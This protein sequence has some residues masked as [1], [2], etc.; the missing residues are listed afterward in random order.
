M[1]DIAMYRATLILLAFGMLVGLAGCPTPNTNPVANAGSDQQVDVGTTVT[2]DGSSS[3]DADGDTLTYQW[4]FDERPDESQTSLSGAGMAGPSFVPDRPGT[5][6]LSL[7]VL[8]TLGS[9]TPDTVTITVAGSLVTVPELAG[10]TEAEAA[11]ALTDAGLI[12]GNTTTLSSPAVPAGQILSQDPIAGFEALPDSA[13]DVVVSSG[14]ASVTVPN[15]TGQPQSDAEAAILGAGLTLGTVTPTPSDTIPEGEVIS[16]SVAPDTVVDEGTA[17]DLVVSAGQPIDLRLANTFNLRGALNDPENENVL[18]PENVVVDAGSSQAYITARLTSHIAIHDL[19]DGMITGTLDSGFVLPGLKYPFLAPD[20]GALYVVD[21]TTSQ[22]ARIDIATNTVTATAP[23]GDGFLDGESDGSSIYI[24][25]SATPSLLVLN[26]DTLAETSS[27]NV[28]D[29]MVGDM[30]MDSANGLLYILDI[31]GVGDDGTLSV[32]DTN[33]SSH[34]DTISFTMP[35]AGASMALRLDLDTVGQRFFILG[36]NGL[37]SYPIDGATPPRA[38]VPRSEF[39]LMNMRYLPGDTSANDRILAV[40]LAKPPSGDVA[41]RGARLFAFNPN[42]GQ[43]TSPIDDVDL[44]EGNVNFDVDPA[45]GTLISP[46]SQTGTVWALDAAPF[47]VTA[48]T[49][50]QVGVNIDQITVANSGLF[51]TSRF[52]GNLLFRLTPEDDT[53]TAFQGRQWPV[54]FRVRGMSTPPALIVLNAWEGTLDQFTTDASPTLSST[55]NTGFSAGS[56]ERLPDM[57]L[58]P[59]GILAAVAYP[60]FGQVRVRNLESGSAIADLDIPNASTG[61]GASSK[62]EL[63]VF[64]HQRDGELLYVLDREQSMLHRYDAAD[65]YAL[66]GSTD[67]SAGL[68]GMADAPEKDW[69]FHDTGQERLY[70]GPLQIDPLSG[71]AAGDALPVGQIVRGL[72]EDRGLYWV[73]TQTA[74][75]SGFMVDIE[76][77]SRST[78]E[79]ADTALSL[80]GTHPIAPEFAFDSAER[81]FFVGYSTTAE[82][83]EYNY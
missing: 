16:Q 3:S 11:T 83:E 65:S 1:R 41:P 13:V 23:V 69:F 15:L 40:G 24:T 20:G 44:G 19:A 82:I 50:L 49:P 26:G 31:M 46:D 70:I 76:T 35:G 81:R 60:E 62:G 57:A 80:A 18:R 5:Y 10:L 48:V 56:T 12:L 78:N 58:H 32:Y 75:D 37:N 2:L 52:G 25:R 4:R 28:L 72:D 14:P 6:V 43:I 73:V 29:G 22:I 36:T 55:V 45:M 74:G 63:Q 39:E 17:I 79:A 33:S 42:L 8:D 71:V 47:P 59:G 51:G 66:L 53:L 30:E 38:L 64:F 54:P 61:D 27:S 68:A 9:S 21:R 77:V 7:T 67:L 34:T